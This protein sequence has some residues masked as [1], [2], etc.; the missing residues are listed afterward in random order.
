MA[1]QFLVL[2]MARQWKR[3]KLVR[4]LVVFQA[5]LQAS[6]IQLAGPRVSLTNAI[7]IRP[8][9]LIKQLFLV[10]WILIPF[11]KF[12]WITCRCFAIVIKVLSI[13][14]NQRLMVW[15]V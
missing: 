14:L 3:Q 1:R 15:F 10:E 13:V 7:F 11:A 9:Y 5:R 4:M 2:A 6:W 12:S 8:V